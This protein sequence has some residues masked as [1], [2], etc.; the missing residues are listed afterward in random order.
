MAAVQR[1]EKTLSTFDEVNMFFD[2]AAERLGLADGVSEMLRR[3]WREL[4]VS[5]PVRMDSGEIKVFSGYRIQHNGARG[6]YKGGVR[7][8]PDADQEEVRALASLM[9]WKTALVDI[10]FG[11]AKGGVRCDPR[12]MSEGELNR[13]TRRYTINIEH[14]LAVNRDI[15]APDLGTNAQTM[16]WMMDAYSQIHGYTPAIVTGKPVELGGSVG[17][18]AATGRGTAYVMASAAKEYGIELKG[19]RVVVQGF[20]QVG[21][22]TAIL[23]AE[24]G[25]K[26]IGVSDVEGG[27]Y[28]ERGVDVSKALEHKRATGSVVGAPGTERVTNQELLELECEFLVPAAI[29]RV[30]HKG[31]APRVR[32][33]VVVEAANHPLTPEADAILNDRGIPILPDIL[34][35]AG[36]VTV[37]YFEWTQNLYQHQWPEERV[38]SE[39]EQIMAKAY[40]HVVETA[41]KERITLREAAFLIG[42]GRVA[43]VAK[44]RGF[45]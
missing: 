27:A 16:A 20:G 26:V 44:L 28:S 39:L 42:V 41:E 38:S 6:P 8:H 31:N 4:H 5:V 14:L 12:A 34:V 40:R 13:L 17:R 1:R 2:R 29:D 43:H 35:N 9:T 36:G 10:P 11:G 22:W 19:A 7:Y 45:I 18:E 3:P 23:L 33:K 32:A 15:P 25:C 30:I 21:S 24:M 37:S